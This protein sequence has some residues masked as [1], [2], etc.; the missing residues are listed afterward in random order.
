M[1]NN[2]EFRRANTDDVDSIY[3]LTSSMA[4]QG[5]MLTRSKYKIVTSLTSFFVAEDKETGKVIACGSLAP[6]WTDLCEI[7]ALAVHPV[8]QGRGIGAALVNSLV[9]EAERLKINQVITLTYQVKFFA[10]QGFETRDKNDFPRKLWRECLEC[11][12]LEHCDETAMI[13]II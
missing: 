7:C 12:K 10:K 11:P 5:L 8:W 2:I 9:A 1:T 6:L 13:K 3:N 4:S